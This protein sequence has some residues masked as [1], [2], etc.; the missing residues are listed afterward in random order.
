MINKVA[1][2]GRTQSYAPTIQDDFEA[3]QNS[4]SLDN[5]DEIVG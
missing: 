1:I 3:Y 2:V 4:T 5:N